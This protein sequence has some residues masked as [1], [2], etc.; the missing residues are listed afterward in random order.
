MMVLDAIY[1]VSQ[2][3]SSMNPVML[4]QPWMKLVP[5][6]EEDDFQSFPNEEF[7]K[8]EIIDRVCA[9][10]YFKNVDEGNVE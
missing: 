1:S 3:W 6:I 2:A 5:N 10:R 8:S 9:M 7:S 4:V